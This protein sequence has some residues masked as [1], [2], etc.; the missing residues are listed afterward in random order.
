MGSFNERP[1]IFALSN[2]T[3]RAECTAQAA[4]TNTDGRVIFASGSPFGEV[5]HNGKT[6][7]P[8]Q[9]NNAY[10]FPGV[11]MGVILT[12][13]HHISEEMFLIAAQCIADSV[14]DEDLAR[15]SLYPPLSLVKECSL[16]IASK[17]CQHAYD[18]GTASVYP[19]PVDKRAYI[20]AQ[21]YNFNYEPSL[22]NTWSWPKSPEIKT[23]PLEPVKLTG[24]L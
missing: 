24:K 17:I 16:N 1:V 3:D 22:P 15:G 4:Y 5:T 23:R 7:K 19:E 14:T 21:L 2:P 13:I 6:F 12:G 8:G 10:I 9:G 11:A 20:E 18:K